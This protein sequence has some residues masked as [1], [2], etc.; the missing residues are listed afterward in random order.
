VAEIND[1]EW[2]YVNEMVKRLDHHILG[3]GKPPL[4]ERL[5]SYID[6]RDAHKERNT[7]QDLADLREESDKKHDQNTKTLDKMSDKQDKIQQLVYIGM[8]I[9]IALESVGLF[10]K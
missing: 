6:I 4:E 9:M 1:A 7:Q 10:K 2:Y 8:G 3:N 5:K